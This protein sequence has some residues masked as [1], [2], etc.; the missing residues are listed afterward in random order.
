MAFFK[1]KNG[2]EGHAKL[3]ENYSQLVNNCPAVNK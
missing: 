3:A 1:I 2:G